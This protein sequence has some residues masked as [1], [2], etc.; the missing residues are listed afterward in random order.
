MWIL[1]MFKVGW[2]VLGLNP[3]PIIII[4]FVIV[5]IKI[6]KII[7]DNKKDKLDNIIEKYNNNENKD[8]KH[9][10]TEH[11]N[12]YNEHFNF[13][14]KNNWSINCWIIENIKVSFDK[15]N[16][17]FINEKWNN[18]KNIFLYKLEND[19]V[20]IKKENYE[21]R[22][23]IMY[24]EY[25][26]Y[27]P[28]EYSKENILG[29]STSGREQIRLKI[30]QQYLSN[31]DFIK[32][33]KNEIAKIDRFVRELQNLDEEIWKDK[34]FDK[35][36]NTNVD[37]WEYWDYLK[38]YTKN[39]LIVYNLY[40]SKDNYFFDYLDYS[41]SDFNFK[42]KYLDKWTFIRIKKIADKIRDKCN[43]PYYYWEENLKILE[44]FIWEKQLYKIN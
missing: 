5:I 26:D 35:Y 23:D 42:N 14:W 25:D 32:Y 1:K 20:L 9:Q 27:R 22:I 38:L 40:Y 44:S 4:T 28:K 41:D 43:I 11:D 12:E 31:D 24:P 7:V 2:K 18:V 21:K 39:Y 19:K 34:N 17:T 37:T 8:I 36:W 10:D 13:E 33:I 29:I 16:I 6:I 30:L 15:N 3:I